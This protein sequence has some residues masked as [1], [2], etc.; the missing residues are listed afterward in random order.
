MQRPESSLSDASSSAATSASAGASSSVVTRHRQ[1]LQAVPGGPRK[2]SVKALPSIPSRTQIQA[3]PQPQQQLQQQ[4]QPEQPEQE[5]RQEHRQSKNDQPP[6]YLQS[7]HDSQTQSQRRSYTPPPTSAVTSDSSCSHPPM[8]LFTR[9]DTPSSMSA[10]SPVRTSSPAPVLEPLEERSPPRQA[11]LPR[12]PSSSSS[13]SSAPLS[14]PG[15]ASQPTLRTST[16]SVPSVSKPPTPA[17]ESPVSGSA[18][19]RPRMVTTLSTPAPLQPPPSIDFSSVPVPF[20]ALTLDAA[21]WTFSS[22]EL[23]A[24]VSRAIRASAEPSSIRLL[25]L[26]VID[27]DLV[28]EAERL[29]SERA[30][31]TAQYRFTMHRRNMLLQSLNA[32]S[33]PSIS[34]S[35]TYSANTIN[36]S[37]NPPLSPAADLA[38]R[39]AEVSATLDRLAATLVRVSDQLAQIRSLRDVHSASALAVALRKLNASFARRTREL[40]T[41]KEKLAAAEEERD[42]AWR[43]AEE[44]AM[45]YDEGLDGTAEVDV[46]NGERAVAVP[47]TLT[48]ASRVGM[49]IKVP[50]VGPRIQQRQ[51]DAEN[52]ED[53]AVP[54]DEEERGRRTETNNAAGDSPASAPGETTGETSTTTPITRRKRANSATS[55]V[56][57]ARTRSVRASKASLRFPRRQH[58]SRPPSTYSTH[59]TQSG[60][61][62]ARSRSRANSISSLRD[63]SPTSAHPHGAGVNVPIPDVPKMPTATELARLASVKSTSS[64]STPTASTTAT[65]ALP[66]IPPPPPPS[67]ETNLSKIGSFL[68]MTTRPNS[69]TDE[70]GKSPEKA[71]P[72]SGAVVAAGTAQGEV[73][74]SNGDES[75][76]T[77]TGSIGSNAQE[78]ETLKHTGDAQA[79]GGDASSTTLDPDERVDGKGRDEEVDGDEPSPAPKDDEAQV[80]TVPPRSDL[81]QAPFSA[82]H[83]ETSTNTPDF[84]EV[85]EAKKHLQVRPSLQVYPPTWTRPPPDSP[86]DVMR[87][88]GPHR[89]DNGDDDDVFDD[90]NEGEDEL[91]DAFESAYARTQLQTATRGRFA[92]ARSPLRVHHTQSMLP[93]PSTNTTAIN[94]NTSTGGAGSH[95]SFNALGS[96][97]HDDMMN[98]MKRSPAS[99]NQI[100]MSSGSGSGSG[101]FRGY[102]ASASTRRPTSLPSAQ[103]EKKPWDYF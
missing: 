18:Y 65:V 75:A 63:G 30:Q 62:R 99:D 24:I 64:T 47:A 61:S 33:G 31:A 2:P 73:V 1:R 40:E 6:S 78:G 71:N 15:S 3:R 66:P 8:S 81:H 9:A 14:G 16:S 97:A 7:Q 23:Q 102:E 38:Q 74:D 100:T 27:D 5:R 52:P 101:P 56:T 79:S 87:G 10:L 50:G 82:S 29:E 17:P 59:S 49:R 39:L 96:G 90:E 103:G 84:A 22:A 94:T 37:Q 41:V 26:Q 11:S 48:R 21:Q 44:M 95:L 43:V 45:E 67:I 32:S 12:I 85:A 76:R 13:S 77:G 53:G 58:E 68:D 70:K 34:P 55:R 35:T 19:S 69:A 93:F 42:E 83:V 89:A 86:V 25:P 92:Y 60:P 36:L 98:V 46:V 72:A 51:P 4:Q 20:K 54:E 91:A 28:Q 88:S 80:I 57:A